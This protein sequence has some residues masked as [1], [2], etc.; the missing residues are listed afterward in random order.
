M[1]LLVEQMHKAVF[2][3]SCW[4]SGAALSEKLGVGAAREL[5]K[6]S[7]EKARGQRGKGGPVLTAEDE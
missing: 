3:K 4:V 7:L 6:A 5:S 1:A 2:S